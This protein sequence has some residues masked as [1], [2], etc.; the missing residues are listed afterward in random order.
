MTDG[1]AL[2]VAGGVN[3]NRPQREPFSI[4]DILGDG[5]LWAVPRSR[6]TLERRHTRRFG[7]PNGF[8]HGVVKMIQKKT[9]LRTCNVCGDDH[10]IG[11]L[12]RKD[13]IQ[14]IWGFKTAIKKNF[15]FSAT[16]TGGAR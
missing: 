13:A 6:R 12:C 2:A 3:G 5:F 11:V 15:K 9:T 1:F 4:K 8:P 7:N 16:L 14:R 10:E